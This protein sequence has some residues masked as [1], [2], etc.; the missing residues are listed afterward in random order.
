MNHLKYH[1]TPYNGIKKNPPQKLG[2]LDSSMN[3]LTISTAK[4]RRVIDFWA[5]SL[6]SINHKFQEDQIPSLQI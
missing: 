5:P 3:F 4:Q 1:H 6:S 2:F